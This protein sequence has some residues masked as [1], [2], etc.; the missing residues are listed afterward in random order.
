MPFSLEIGHR[1]HMLKLV[2]ADLCVVLAL[3]VFNQLRNV[4]NL[5]LVHLQEKFPGHSTWVDY[6]YFLKIHLRKLQKA[7]HWLLFSSKLCPILDQ[8]CLIVSLS[9]TELPE[10][11]SFNS[12][13]YSY[14]LYMEV[15]SPPCSEWHH[16]T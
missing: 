16:K 8:N 10:N 12:G 11:H 5:I 9:Q 1:E 2:K 7:G 4:L 13:I 3:L 14:S 15:P 6:R